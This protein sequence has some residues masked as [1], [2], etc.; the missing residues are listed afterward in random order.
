MSDLETTGLENEL[1]TAD[2]AANSAES[3]ED[4]ASLVLTWDGSESEARELFD[5]WGVAEMFDNDF[6]LFLQYLDDYVAM[7]EQV[8]ADNQELIANDETAQDVGE[9]G[10]LLQY[11]GQQTVAGDDPS[12]GYIDDIQDVWLEAIDELNAKYGLDTAERVDSDG[13]R[14]HWTGTSWNRYYEAPSRGWSVFSNVLAGVATSVVTGDRGALGGAIS[15]ALPGLSA[16]ASTALG[17]TLAS[18]ITQAVATGGDVDIRDA[19]MQGLQEFVSLEGI[20]D[21]LGDLGIEGSTPE[22]LTDLLD[23]GEEFLGQVEELISTGI[24]PIDAMIQAGGKDVLQQLVLTGEIDPQQALLSMA[25]TGMVEGVE[26]LMENYGDQFFDTS[27]RY[28]ILDENGDIVHEFDS[29]ET[30]SAWADGGNGTD[31]LF[32]NGP[33]GLKLGWSEVEPNEFFEFLM[34]GGG[35]AALEGGCYPRRVERR[36]H[37]RDK[38]IRRLSAVRV[39]GRREVQGRHNRR[40]L[41]GREHRRLDSRY[42]ILR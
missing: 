1:L 15:S 8:L 4:F 33:D 14:Y 35:G 30:A 19:L 10:G 27:T 21:L 12:V 20:S 29:Y 36:L 26:W 17:N 31:R 25:Q 18:V 42:D 11:V 16:T 22:W 6:D 37:P 23:K 7:R 32:G 34:E 38:R 5:S 40:G 39:R 9:A 13:N 41:D 3:E 28:Y 24:E 2:T